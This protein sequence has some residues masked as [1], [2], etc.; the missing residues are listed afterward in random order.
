MAS[1]ADVESAL[2]EVL[3][4]EYP[5]SL[6]DLGLIRGVRVEGTTAKVDIAYCSL[7]CPCI[8]LIEH[9]VEER[10]LQLDGIDRVELVESFDRWTRGDVSRR[11][12]ELLRRAGVG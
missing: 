2:A 3:D 5:V 11:G 9:D 8:N 12:L 7:G 4:P 10:L 1:R 6:V